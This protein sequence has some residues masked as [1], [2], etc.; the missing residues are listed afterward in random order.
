MDNPE[1]YVYKYFSKDTY[2]LVYNHIINLLS[3]IEE[4][5]NSTNSIEIHPSI[6]SKLAGRQKKEKV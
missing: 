1:K 6:V 3:S 5:N 2:V 4:H